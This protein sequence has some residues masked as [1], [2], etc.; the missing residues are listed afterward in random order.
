MDYP[1]YFTRYRRGKKGDSYQLSLL[2]EVLY[3]L[4]DSFDHK[5]LMVAVVGIHNDETLLK[6][7]TDL[8]TRKL[9]II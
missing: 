4:F 6:K 9:R 1:L 7:S 8:S 3:F 5:L 2:Y